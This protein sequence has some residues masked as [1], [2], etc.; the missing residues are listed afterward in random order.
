MDSTN[1]ATNGRSWVRSHDARQLLGVSGTLTILVDNNNKD[2][3]TPKDIGQMGPPR[4]DCQHAS[5]WHWGSDN[6]AC[7]TC[8]P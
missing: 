7:L 5:A 3:Q 2:A 1:D 4:V 6:T 8:G